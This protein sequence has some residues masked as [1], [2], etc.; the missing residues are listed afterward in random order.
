MSGSSQPTAMYVC[1]YVC[2]WFFL[3][4]ITYLYEVHMLGL[5]L[6][7]K[8]PDQVFL[9]AKLKTSFRMSYDDLDDRYES[10]TMAHKCM[11]AHFLAWY[12]HINK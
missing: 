12:R 6:T 4:L 3:N 5:L 1:M 7:R 10:L 9:V 2:V 8:R 11:T